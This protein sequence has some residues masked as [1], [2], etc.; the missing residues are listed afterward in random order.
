[1][2][3]SEVPYVGLND[4]MHQG[5]LEGS[6]LRGDGAAAFSYSMEEIAIETPQ[7][8]GTQRRDKQLVTRCIKGNSNQI[9]A[10]KKSFP[11]QQLIAKRW[12]LRSSGGTSLLGDTEI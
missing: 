1:M 6:K 5:R 9:Q 3:F 12:T 11:E 4:P 7:L 8:R 10:R 2:K